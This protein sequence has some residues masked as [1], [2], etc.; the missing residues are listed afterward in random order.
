[1][2]LVS[3]TRPNTQHANSSRKLFPLPPGECAVK[4]ARL[5]R[6]ELTEAGGSLEVSRQLFYAFY[7]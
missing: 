1:M 7:A 5:S 4:E 6:L 2:L 3:N